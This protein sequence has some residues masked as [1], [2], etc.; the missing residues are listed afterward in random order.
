MI[1]LRYNSE[2]ESSKYLCGCSVSAIKAATHPIL[3][4]PH[5][6]NSVVLNAELEIYNNLEPKK[7]S[8]S[9]EHFSRIQELSS[10]CCEQTQ[11]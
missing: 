6:K 5:L 1:L 2:V 11:S 8:L 4:R 3:L 9:D 7:K 10:A